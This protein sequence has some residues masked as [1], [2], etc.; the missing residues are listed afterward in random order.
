M[1]M[2]GGFPQG[3][4]DYH[5]TTSNPLPVLPHVTTPGNFLFLVASQAQAF[6]DAYAPTLQR[7]GGVTPDYPWTIGA[8]WQIAYAIGQYGGPGEHIGIGLW[9]RRV[10]P[11]EV[12]VSPVQAAVPGYS[13]WLWE[14]KYGGDPGA[15]AVY[16]TGDG[17][18]E[19]GGTAE[20]GAALSGFRV[21]AFAVQQTS[22]SW[23]PQVFAAGSTSE[24]QST[25]EFNETDMHRT[26]WGRIY[27]FVGT[28]E[29]G[30]VQATVD[31]TMFDDQIV[32]FH[33][34]CGVAIELP[35]W[36]LVPTIPYP[37]N[38][39]GVVEAGPGHVAIGGHVTYAA[40]MA[41]GRW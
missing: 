12:T 33:G 41:G 11:G 34:V 14:F 1:I 3:A 37:E 32:N 39:T 38:Q 6:G 8:P 19:N 4:F 7:Q 24:V 29:S 22:Y 2:G 15:G 20:V 17:H 13:L 27:T 30:P 36:Y 25:N 23:E 35:G 16:T 40:E 10:Q 18:L 31:Y 28:T 5:A 9:W 26:N 21:G